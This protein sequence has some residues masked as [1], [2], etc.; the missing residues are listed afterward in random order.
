MIGPRS[1]PRFL[2]PP[3]Q[4]FA[5][6]GL[7]VVVAGC[8]VESYETRMN[9]TIDDLK[10]ENRFIGLAPAYTKLIAPGK[11]SLVAISP[12]LKVP[13]QPALF[14]A[15]TAESA[16]PENLNMQIPENRVL[17]PAPLPAVPGYQET[18]EQFVTSGSGIRPWYLYV[19][20]IRHEP[21]SGGGAA[22]LQ[23]ILDQVRA[24]EIEAATKAGTAPPEQSAYAWTDRTIM[25]AK[26]GAPARVWKTLDFEGPQLF[27]V[28]GNEPNDVNGIYRIMV[29]DV[30]AKAPV[31]DHQIFLVWRFVRTVNEMQR[32]NDLMN[33]CVGTLEID[34]APPAA[35]KPN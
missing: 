15:Y 16:N 24:N 32:L 18:F 3:A 27:Y 20:V 10:H 7:F 25:S 14:A 28:R 2:A 11:E 9:A 19:G 35:P 29:L 1:L 22:T 23:A 5:V 17:P 26:K 12:R 4:L 34:P 21:G 8:G 31:G 13:V 6:L 30:P 33:A